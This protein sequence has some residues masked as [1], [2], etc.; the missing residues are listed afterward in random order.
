MT[1]AAERLLQEVAYV[2]YHFHWA[3]EEILDL[4]HHERRRWVGEIARINTRVNE[5]R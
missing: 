4:E 2:A 1:Y 3:R 5:G